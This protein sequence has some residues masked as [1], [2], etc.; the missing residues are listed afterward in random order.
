M[1][2]WQEEYDK[3]YEVSG[4]MWSNEQCL[5]LQLSLIKY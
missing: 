5:Q 1:F 4:N 3:M 2:D